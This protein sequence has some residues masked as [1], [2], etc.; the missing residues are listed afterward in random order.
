MKKLINITFVRYGI[1]G[2]FNTFLY[3]SI[4]FILIKEKLFN[5][6][7]STA[8]AM[9][10]TSL[11]HF[12]FNKLFTFKVNVFSYNELLKYILACFI[13]YL[14]ALV[15]LNFFLNLMD[16]GPLF[17]TFASSGITMVISF[18]VSRFWVFKIS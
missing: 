15:S 1:V 10:F 9:I 13:N 17:S 2:I 5:L 14:A 4:L 11:S 7:I 6:Q 18:C 3:F 16:I 8:I 12:L